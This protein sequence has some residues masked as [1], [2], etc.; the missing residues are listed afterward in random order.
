MLWN[1]GPPIF[2]CINLG[3]ENI[4]DSMNYDGLIGDRRRSDAS[5]I[6]SRLNNGFCSCCRRV[7]LWARLTTKILVRNKMAH[8][9]TIQ[10]PFFTQ[11]LVK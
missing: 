1:T 3:P 10:A 11:L 8:F 7:V 4:S 5:D 2:C 6:Q 9:M